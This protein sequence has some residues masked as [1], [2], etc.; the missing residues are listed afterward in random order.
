MFSLFDI[1]G[2][3]TPS[4]DVLDVGAMVEGEPRYFPIYQA[5]AAN[6]TLIEPN[7]NEIGLL[8]QAF[9]NDPRYLQY[10][11]GDG[12]S[13]TLHLTHYPGC[14]SIFAPD[15]TVIDNFVS[16]DTGPGANFEVKKT[17]IVETTRLDDISPAVEADY[18]KIDVQGSEL[19]ILE[20]ATKTLEQVLVIEAEVEF[21]PIYKDQPLFGDLQIFMRSQGFVLHKLIDV[22][23]RC[24]MPQYFNNNRY[25]GM[26][27]MLWADAIFVRDFTALKNYSTAGLLKTAYVMHDMYG[28]FDFVNFLLSE[29]DLREGTSLAIRYIQKLSAY[30]DLPRFM[31]N[32][33]EYV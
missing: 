12:C 32:A 5:G 30:P 15:P 25:A 6:L 18:I 2:P 8:R 1:L 21:L 16:I 13:A 26:S 17:E 20:N 11:L 23:S 28:S 7:E 27:Q 31:L 19:G 22:A 24:F 33:K 9:G 3:A 10:F 29:H 14:T 4:I